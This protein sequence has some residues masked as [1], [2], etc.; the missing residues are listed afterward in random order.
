M[1]PSCDGAPPAS[2]R[3]CAAADESRPPGGPDADAA[4]PHGPTGRVMI[5]VESA[6]G[7]TTIFI[8]GELDLVTM[9][10]LAEQLTLVA[11][12]MPGR[13]LFDLAGT[14]FLDCG[15]ARLIAG[16]GEWLPEGRR[17][18]I[19]GPGPAVRRIL[20]LTGLDACCEIEE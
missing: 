10:F 18:V 8:R 2:G 1:P 16:A 5:E 19:R 11:R 17:P 14:S 3:H 9:P 12:D 6:P 13:L 20:K 7:V 15:S 4:V